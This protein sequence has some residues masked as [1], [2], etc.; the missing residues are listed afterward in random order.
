MMVAVDVWYTQLKG[1]AHG[2]YTEN[3][4]PLTRLAASKDQ[5]IDPLRA[6]YAA[7]LRSLR[8]SLTMVG[9]DIR[10]DQYREHAVPEIS[11]PPVSLNQGKASLVLTNG[12][13]Q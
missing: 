12:L 4:P 1:T 8:R 10:Q 3:A 6:T 7:E 5:F 13:Q 2:R 9:K 11:R